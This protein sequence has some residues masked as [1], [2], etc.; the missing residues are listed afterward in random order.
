MSTPSSV[1]G[2]KLSYGTVHLAFTVGLIRF[3]RIGINLQVFIWLEKK[4]KVLIP[5]KTTLIAQTVVKFPKLV[6]LP[7]HW[8]SEYNLTKN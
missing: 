4:G 6:V 2:N 5:S 3:D 7:L 1:I 8:Y